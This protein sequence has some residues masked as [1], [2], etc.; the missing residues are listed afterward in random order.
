[1]E[2]S[3][4]GVLKLLVPADTPPH[5]TSYENHVTITVNKCAYHMTRHVTV[6]VTIHVTIHVTAHVTVHV[7]GHVMSHLSLTLSA[8][9]GFCIPIGL[10]KSLNMAGFCRSS[11][12]LSKSTTTQGN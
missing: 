8:S 9:L 12:A 1:M 11:S 10:V 3:H 2:L 4:R 7:T 5:D 6:H